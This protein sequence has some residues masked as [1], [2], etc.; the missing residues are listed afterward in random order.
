MISE[1]ELLQWLND[2]QDEV[3]TKAI[4]EMKISK[5]KTANYY[6]GMADAFYDVI[7][8]IWE[9]HRRERLKK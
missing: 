5:S 4:E 7:N 2:K 8:K 1:Q 9:I 6:D 3:Q